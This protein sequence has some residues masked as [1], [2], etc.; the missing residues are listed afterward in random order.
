[1]KALNLL[2]F[3]ILL[4]SSAHGGCLDIFA[5][6]VRKES[7]FQNAPE[8]ELRT[9]IAS[10]ERVTN[11][12]RSSK[13]NSEPAINLSIWKKIDLIND[14]LFSN[15]NA[16]NER[17]LQT[18]FREYEANLISFQRI[19]PLLLELSSLGNFD[20][21]ALKQVLDSAT[22]T[23]EFKDFILKRFQ[24]AV[25]SDSFLKLLKSEKRR[26]L[27]ALGN[28][29]QEYRMIRGHLEDIQ[30]NANCSE[31]CQDLAQRLLLRIGATSEK[32]KSLHKL[33]FAGESRPNIGQ[34]RDSLYEEPLFV[35]T[36][37]KRERNLELFY[38]IRSIFL[39]PEIMDRI[40]GLIYKSNRMGKFRA[41]QLFKWIYNMQARLLHFPKINR[42]VYGPTDI[43]KSLGLLKEVNTTIAKDELLVSFSRRVDLLSSKKWDSILEHAKSN[44][45]SFYERMVEASKK[46]VARGEISPVHRKSSAARIASVF[47]F[48][49]SALTYFYHDEAKSILNSLVHAFS[50]EEAQLDTIE[51]DGEEDKILEEASEVIADSIEELGT[52]RARNPSSLK[53]KEGFWS[54]FLNF[55]S[56]LF[57]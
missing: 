42:L 56:R 50:D 15:R 2:I 36:K 14:F 20:E 54:T 17:M 5:K 3:S 45:S 16:V 13:E 10:L 33:F 35:L 23:S 44:D 48:S 11:F 30:M 47:V 32:E 25:S 55:F 18:F 24:G 4:I 27:I 43:D 28:H 8:Y 21:A 19:Q 37:L 34:F 38:F 7:G 46:G 39:Q 41:I 9:K 31:L 49:S 52:D 53:D 57:S 40:L 29:Y 6:L 12:L 22:Y 26:L 51:F 1:M